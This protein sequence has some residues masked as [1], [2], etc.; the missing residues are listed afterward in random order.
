MRDC[1]WDSS[2]RFFFYAFSNRFLP[3]YRALS[4]LPKAGDGLLGFN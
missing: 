4:I 2:R 1:R 3:F